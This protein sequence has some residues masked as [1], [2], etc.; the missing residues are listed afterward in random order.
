MKILPVFK[1]NA[2]I[3]YVIYQAAAL[4]KYFSVVSTYC[5]VLKGMPAHFY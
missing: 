2:P 5:G 1:E 3:F 4:N